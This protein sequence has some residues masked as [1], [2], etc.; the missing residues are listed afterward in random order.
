VEAGNNY[1]EILARDWA[2]TP[3]I[4][5]LGFEIYEN[6]SSQLTSA[7]LL[8][9]LNIHSSSSQWRGAG[10]TFKVYSS[11]TCSTCP[12]GYFLKSIIPIAKTSGNGILNNAM[13]SASAMNYASWDI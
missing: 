6:T 1:F 9:S 13:L 8:S 4:G 5:A 10:K 2:T 12:D 11:P 3:L 7:T